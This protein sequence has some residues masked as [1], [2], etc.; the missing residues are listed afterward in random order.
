MTDF[1]HIQFESHFL[2]AVV[3]GKY[4]QQDA[5]LPSIMNLLEND[6]DR[7]TA[8]HYCA[9]YD[10]LITFIK[11]L[12]CPHPAVGL[13]FAQKNN[14]NLTALDIFL[15]KQDNIEEFID[16]LKDKPVLKVQEIKVLINEKK[17]TKFDKF[18]DFLKD[19]Q[20][21][22]SEDIISLLKEILDVK[23]QYLR[24]LLEKMKHRT[25][26]TTFVEILGASL[27]RME[28]LGLNYNAYLKSIIQ[29]F[30]Q[31]LK[32]EIALNQYQVYTPYGSRALTTPVESTLDTVQSKDNSLLL[33]PKK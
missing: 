25:L 18:I 12:D 10:Y 19:Y 17:Y 4:E 11:I 15:I 26:S 32:Q 16:F 6:N 8:L 31:K 30:Y 20:D 9:H 28:N 13:L 21:L 22:S 33:A 5:E 14:Q 29:E 27:A 1:K 3:S 2:D 24:T 23:A 7:N